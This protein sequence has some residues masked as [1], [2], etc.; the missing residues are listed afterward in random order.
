MVDNDSMGPSLQ[1]FRARFLNFSPVSGHVT[2]EVC[3]ILISPESTA[4]YVRAY[5]LIHLPTYLQPWTQTD[6][7]VL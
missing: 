6:F 2:F 4:F 5:L 7:G 1:L 3:E